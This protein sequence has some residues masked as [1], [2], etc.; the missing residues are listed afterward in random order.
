LPVNLND[1]APV[2]RFAP[3]HAAWRGEVGIVGMAALAAG[4]M[5]AFAIAE[6]VAR[7]ALERLHDVVALSAQLATAAVAFLV[8][9]WSLLCLWRSATRLAMASG[10]F[11]VAALVKMLAVV[12]AIV[13]LDHLL[14]GMVLRV[15]ILAGRLDPAVADYR[16]TRR[17]ADVAFVGA[18]TDRAVADLLRQLRDPAVKVLR[19][20]SPGGLIAP[21]MT[22]ARA[23]REQGTAVLAEGR[24]LSSCTLLLAASPQAIMTPTAAIAFHRPTPLAGVGGPPPAA[25]ERATA[26][27][28]ASFAAYGLADWALQEMARR[29]IWQPALGQLHA[30]GLIDSVLADEPRRILPVAAYCAAEPAR[31]AGAAR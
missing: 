28:Y 4:A 10:R 17:G 23:I 30:M 6:L 7:V 27:Y 22:L 26:Q 2:S 13:A 5:L 14:S 9:L 20:D 1:T 11:A 29:E 12:L 8:C 25:L 31:C 19:I 15:R 3:L 24:C 16:V 21:A 18:I